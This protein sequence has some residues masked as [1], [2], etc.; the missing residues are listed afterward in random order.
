VKGALA[1]ML[2]VTLASCQKTAQV[3]VQQHVQSGYVDG[4]AH[5]IGVV[6]RFTLATTEPKASGLPADLD[7]KIALGPI[8][9]SLGRHPVQLLFPSE[10]GYSLAPAP[11]LRA[12]TWSIR[13]GTPSEETVHL[14]AVATGPLSQLKCGD[15][16]PLELE[17]RWRIEETSGRGRIKSGLQ[18][19][20]RA[21]GFDVVVRCRTHE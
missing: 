10:V 21:Q 2:L 15:V 8:R 16:L 1:A 3:D 11:D 4:P 6:S 5:L 9:A 20:A 17:T 14:T 19:A 12:A 18:G 13:G 7:L